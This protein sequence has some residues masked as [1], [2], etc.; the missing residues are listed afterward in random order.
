MCTISGAANAHP[1]HLAMVHQPDTWEPERVSWENT[2]YRSPQQFG[3]Q[4][5][6]AKVLIET[7]AREAREIIARDTPQKPLGSAAGQRKRTRLG[8]VANLLVNNVGIWIDGYRLETQE[9]GGSSGLRRVRELRDDYGWV[10]EN[11]PH[12]THSSTDQYRL[13]ELP[14]EFRHEGA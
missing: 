1:N 11:R 12:P 2:E 4:A 9:I 8:Q 3:E 14:D 7:R 5:R 13:V 10:I 6:H